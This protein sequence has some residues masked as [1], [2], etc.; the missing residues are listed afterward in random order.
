MATRTD[1]GSGAREWQRSRA[2][3]ILEDFEGIGKGVES[4]GGGG[5]FAGMTFTQNGHFS[6][7][8]VKH[9]RTRVVPA[10]A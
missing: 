2:G 4:G 8:P 1:E 3:K 7:C 5:P 6:F 9:G 10:R